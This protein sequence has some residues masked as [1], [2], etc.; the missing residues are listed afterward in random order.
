MNEKREEESE[1]VVVIS[2]TESRNAVE[3]TSFHLP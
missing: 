2:L 3:M 1:Q